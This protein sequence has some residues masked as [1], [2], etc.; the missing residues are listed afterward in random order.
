M[1]IPPSE[2][3][4]KRLPGELIGRTPDGFFITKIRPDLLSNNPN[5]VSELAASYC[6]VFNETGEKEWSENW[7]QEAAEENINNEI[8]REGGSSVFSLLFSKDRKLQGFSYGHIKGGSAI[9]LEELPPKNIDKTE[10]NSG[11]QSILS[12]ISKHEEDDYLFISELGIEKISRGGPEKPALLTVGLLV[13]AKQKGCKRFFFWTSENTYLYNLSIAL[14]FKLVYKFND[15]K[16][17]VIFIADIDDI[18]QKLSQ[19]GEDIKKILK[20]G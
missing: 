13:E 12:E 16:K 9:N 7:T 5:L 11:L 6:R 18:L 2:D 3:R 14:G 19:S 20:G 10:L 4:L 17:H 8:N 15:A 1:T